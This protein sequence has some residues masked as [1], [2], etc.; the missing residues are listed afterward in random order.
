MKALWLLMLLAGPAYAASEEGVTLGAMLDP[1]APAYGPELQGFAYPFPLQHYRFTSQGVDL[2]MAYMDVSP[3]GPP[4]G[5]PNGRVA[6]L[7]HGK[8]FC[9]ATWE[10]TI[11]VLAGAGW[12]VI[13]LDQVGW[14][15]SSKPHQYQFS[16]QQLAANTRALLQAAGVE[17]AT[18]VAH[19]TGGMLAVR[20]ALM[21]PDAVARMVL[22]D[23]IGL[24]DWK[25]RG[26]PSIG[27]DG[28]YARELKVS[29]DG[30]RAYE[31]D[32]YYAGTW[33]PAYEGWV[34]MLAGLNR[35]PGHEAVAWDSALIYDMIYTQPVLY[36]FPLLRV[37]TVLMVGGRDTT[38]IGKDLAPPEVRA[39]LGNYPVLAREAAR[40]IPG[41]RLIEF[42]QYGHA[43]QIQAPDV[44]H[45]A[46]LENLDP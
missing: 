24:E 46:L 3:A 26:V 2:D 41:A 18:L 27:V 20:Y 34:D 37:P 29:A 35:G 31:R 7:L 39:T 22:V 12:R 1:Q 13:A 30:I 23:P 42:P 17:R 28:W 11:R 21:F 33:E 14:C 32:T 5:T 44:F 25:A 38:A 9:G 45:K 8:N 36:E 15:A 10:A 43:P 4:A 40:A 19:S 6:V 16:F